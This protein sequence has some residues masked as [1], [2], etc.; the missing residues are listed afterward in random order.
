[1]DRR[2]LALVVA[3]VVCAWLVVVFGQAL[4]SSNAL[5]ARQVH[6]QAVNDDLRARVA[7]GR[8]EITYMQTDPF[9][10]FTSRAFGFGVPN[11]RPFALA[12]GAPPPPS[13]TPLGGGSEASPPPTTPLEDWLR[14][15][16]GR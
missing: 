10:A 14:L 7:A 2:T 1:V 8:A 9:L 13:I 12:D 6:E 11:E 5:A 15:L 4:A 3:L 16:L